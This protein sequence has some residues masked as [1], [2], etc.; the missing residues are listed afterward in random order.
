MNDRT[1]EILGKLIA[2]T[3]VILV[4]VAVVA[5]LYVGIDRL[6]E[7]VVNMD[8]PMAITLLICATLFLSART[9]AKGLLRSRKLNQ[10]ERLR[11]RRAAI[12]RRLLKRWSADNDTDRAE[13][14]ESI[15]QDLVL[16]GSAKLIRSYLDLRQANQRG[17]KYA[18]ALE[19][20]LR[21]IREDIGSRNA[22]LIEG[23]LFALLTTNSPK[24]QSRY[25]PGTV[26]KD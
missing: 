18:K 16:W 8:R 25:E 14:L 4:L 3:I 9:L 15:E 20:C 26:S 21:A 24:L 23:D 10:E 13:D 11:H 12:Y 19:D 17:P 7:W 6:V 22:G 2:A 5:A 1:A